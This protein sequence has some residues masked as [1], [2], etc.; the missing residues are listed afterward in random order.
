MCR[1]EVA[2]M[3]SKDE[4][5]KKYVEGKTIEELAEAYGN[6][7]C[8]AQEFTCAY[9]QRCNESGDYCEDCWINKISEII[10]RQ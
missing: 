1:K 3:I 5:I 7:S 2:N 9:P 8:M 10:E 6:M 4:I